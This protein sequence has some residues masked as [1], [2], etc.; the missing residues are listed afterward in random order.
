MSIRAE[1]IK[2]VESQVMEDV[3]EGGGAPTNHVIADGVS[4]AIYKDISSV[5]R[6]K[7]GVK[8]RKMHLRVN[9]DNTDTLLGV[10]VGCTQPQ[11][12]RLSTLMFTTHQ[13]F[14]RKSDAV[15]RAEANVVPSTQW[16][17]Y[18]LEDHVQGMQVVTLFQH[19]SAEIPP[20]GRA[21]H[22]VQDEKK[23]TELLEKVRVRK[24]EEQIRTY[25]NAQGK[26]YEAREVRCF[27]SAPLKNDLRGSPP[28]EFFRR[29][30]NS[31]LVRDTTNANASNFVGSGKLAQPVAVGDLSLKVD[32]IF[33]QIIP[34]NRTETQLLN[35]SPAGQ[36]QA[37][38]KSGGGAMSFDTSQ[39]FNASNSIA[40]GAPIAP[41]TLEISTSLGKLTDKAGQLLRGD[42]VVGT[43]DYF[44][45]TFQ[46]SQGELGG[47]K[48]IRFV[49]AAKY[50]VIADSVMIKVT[51]E[52]RAY[53]WVVT[54]PVEPAQQSVHAAYC[55]GG[56]WYALYDDGS[57]TLR[58]GN[59]SFGLGRVV[60]N[61]KTITLTTGALPDVGSGVLFFFGVKGQYS[62]A[63]VSSATARARVVIPLPAIPELASL[64]VS[65]TSRDT[66]THTAAVAADGTV[67]GTMTGGGSITGHVDAA[68]KKLY[69]APAK[70]GNYS[71]G[72][73][74]NY[75]ARGQRQTHTG[76]N[77]S[78]AGVLTGNLGAN[79]R[80]ASAQFSFRVEPLQS[81]YD[82]NDKH[83]TVQGRDAHCRDD[84][85]GNIVLQ[86]NLA[87]SSTSVGT[88]DYA[89]GAYTIDTAQSLPISCRIYM[90]AELATFGV[91]AN[92]QMYN[93]GG[94]W[95]GRA[96]K[97]LSATSAVAT[98]VSD[99][100]AGTP[101]TETVR[102][103]AL[104]W[105]IPRGPNGIVEPGSTRTTIA[106]HL[107]ADDGYGNI[108]KVSTNGLITSTKVGKINYTTGLVRLTRWGD[109]SQNEREI[110]AGLN[111][112]NERVITQVAG[113]L[114]T[115]PVIADRFQVVA[116]LEDG[117]EINATAD[118][119]GK[120]TSDNVTGEIDADSGVYML[121]FGKWE[122]AT[123]HQSEW[124]Y[125][126]AN[127]KNGNIFVPKPVMPQSV[128]VNGVA[129]TYA[130]VDGAQIGM[131]P[132]SMPPDGRVQWIREGALM[133]LSKQVSTAAVTVSNGQTLNLGQTDLSRLRVIDKNG[134]GI[135]TGFAHDLD[136]GTV[137]F[138]DIT[139]YTQP[140]T[141]IGY[142]EQ[143]REVTGV[144]IDGTVT[145]GEPVGKAFSSGDSVQTV[146]NMYD[147][148]ARV[149]TVFD[150][151]TWD[152]ITW[153]ESVQGDAAVATY[154]I[155]A[156]PI[157][158]TNRGAVTERW[159]LRF[160]NSTEVEVI[161]QHVGSLGRFSINQD[162]A[163]L[164]EHAVGG[165][166]S[167]FTV[168]AGGWGGGWVAGNVLFVETIGAEASWWGLLCI[169]KGDSSVI[170]HRFEYVV[171]ADVDR[172]G[173]DQT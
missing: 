154:N 135:N 151:A 143:L 98:W 159:A 9:T 73:T 8:M 18:L 110:K 16:P 114:P 91:G 108:T 47:S 15:K 156:H 63:T 21:L 51:A 36:S 61:T 168:K 155:T 99:S 45:G 123:A 82:D 49:P 173:A 65:W 42:A 43:V 106:E 126:A 130:P 52:N 24:V 94:G 105:D 33:A 169:G 27:I 112:S 28:S 85:N 84:G 145:V 141:A 71:C 7:G 144:Q 102:A 62:D 57:G 46:Y 131:D 58:G 2:I 77:V 148:F 80:P 115:A 22:I 127:L 97:C 67:S 107:F 124:W 32:N 53:N 44:S 39:T 34:A 72:Y 23:P 118:A 147:L 96:V 6:A 17:G 11:D 14:D 60:Q 125:D 20:I 12:S 104:E 164:N 4:N 54:L 116:Q 88:I 95:V 142:I 165:A 129:F 117:T 55:S 138:N 134:V 25:F 56:R 10:T 76:F 136:A 30:D 1:D 37:L 170:E 109:I 35:L 89:T 152:G 166:T 150:Q 3:P 79:V 161:G 93:V 75:T 90:L 81:S 40:V 19:P 41:G 172:A 70:V 111:K 38:I 157:V 26:P 121:L 68:N 29:A 13:T 69:L 122:P 87:G 5:D 146:L 128:F 100:P 48:N 86:E 133:V 66:L 171:R 50:Y 31:A 162:V 158:V 59:S 160:V 103:E 132:V 101:A 113:R 153:A 139:G 83:Y 137:T 140:I 92:K 74:L 64:S 78:A 163:P 120:I 119:D 167:Y 149:R